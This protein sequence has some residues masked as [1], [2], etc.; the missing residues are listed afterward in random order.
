MNAAGDRERARVS[1]ERTTRGRFV[2]GG[3]EVAHSSLAS[4]RRTRRS[5]FS[6]AAS[7]HCARNRAVTMSACFLAWFAM[8]TRRRASE[9]SP[10]NCGP[11]RRGKWRQASFKYTAVFQKTRRVEWT[12]RTDLRVVARELLV[13]E[14]E[15]PHDGRRRGVGARARG[16][17]ARRRRH[18]ARARPRRWRERRN[19]AP[20]GSRADRDANDVH[21]ERRVR[22]DEIRG[23]LHAAQMAQGAGDGGADAHAPRRVEAGSRAWAAAARFK[24]RD[25]GAAQWRENPARA[26]VQPGGSSSA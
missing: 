13:R 2:D 9:S 1:R 15:A 20:R 23:R 21:E 5:R 18:R 7:S 3:A 17:L 11:E 8:S 26:A 24:T 6:R 12:A 22:A 19:A 10:R 25:R 4:S 16:R 14:D